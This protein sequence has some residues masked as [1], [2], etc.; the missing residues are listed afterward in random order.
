MC[1]ATVPM[2]PKILLLFPHCTA[3]IPIQV[4]MPE[5]E[6][7]ERRPS[8]KQVAIDAERAEKKRKR[9]QKKS[10]ANKKHKTNSKGRVSSSEEPSSGEDDDLG[11]R[12]NPGPEV[13]QFVDDS[14]D[15]EQVVARNELEGNTEPDEAPVSNKYHL[16]YNTHLC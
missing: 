15:E 2:A 4:T 1:V 5:T 7:R 16:P 14:S 10:K 13:E 6:A 3:S 8:A 9:S 11:G 12:Q